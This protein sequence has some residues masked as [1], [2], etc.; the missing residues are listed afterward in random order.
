MPSM[1][2]GSGGNGVASYGYIINYNASNLRVTTI[3]WNVSADARVIVTIYN[4]GTPVYTKDVTGP[5]VG[6]ENVPG[7]YRLQEVTEDG[8]TFLDL[9]PGI[10]QDVAAYFAKA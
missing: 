6:S 3:D 4:N 2:G 1:V 9:P 10:T 7:N 5:D 8:R